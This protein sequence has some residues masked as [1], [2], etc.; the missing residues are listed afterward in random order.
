MKYFSNKFLGR[1]ILAILLLVAVC[2]PVAHAADPIKDNPASKPGFQLV[3]CGSSASGSSAECDWAQLIAL[4][5]RVVNFLVVISVSLAVMAFCYAGFLYIT[6]FGESGK[7]EQAHTI[8]K[9]TL[10]GVFFVLCGWLIVA[11]ILRVLVDNT[12]PTKIQSIVPFQ[13][14]K[15]IQGQPR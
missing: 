1:S 10:I 14:V 6:A 2:A 15:T 5:N 3:P 8:F 11:T 7:I 13:G 12:D 4:A 9:S